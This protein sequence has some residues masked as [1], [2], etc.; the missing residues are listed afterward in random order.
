[1][2]K[3]GVVTSA[4]GFTI[5]I[6]GLGAKGS[7]NNMAA[8]SRDTT[9]FNINYTMLFVYDS[10]RVSGGGWICYRG[11]DANTNTIGYQLRT[12]SSTRPVT[13]QTGR[14]RILFTSADGGKWVP[15][16]SSSSTSAT[17]SKTVITTPINPWGEIAYYSSTTVLSAG[18]DVGTSA[19]WSQYILTLGYS[20]NRTN[21]ALVMT[22]PA[23]IYVKCTPQANGSAIIDADNPYVEAL[24]STNDGKI[25][26]YLGRSYSATNIELVNWHPVF[27]HDGTGIRFW[28]GKTIPEAPV[29]ADWNATSGLSQILNKPA[30]PSKTSDLTND[31]GFLSQAVTSLEGETGDLYLA[32]STLGNASVVSNVAVV[33][34]V[35]LGDF[36]FPYAESKTVVIGGTR[37]SITPVT[38]KT[39]VTSASGA[40]ASYQSGILTITNGSFSTGD[41]VTNGT[42]ISVY[43]TL[44]TDS[45]I[46]W[47]EGSYPS[48][49]YSTTLVPT[50]S[51]SAEQVVIGITSSRT[52]PV[53]NRGLVGYATVE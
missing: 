27:Y 40:T 38:K 42:A 7:Y 44:S 28:T 20:F 51:I 9:L 11:Y 26:I 22:Y 25:Y 53:V 21:V 46:E 2:L 16:N 52:A 43:T 12:N 33:T 50:L 41:S 3:N 48:I 45:S 6:N 29:N 30:I 5:N 34:G 19:L 17:A 32:H 10:T 36:S 13:D 18:T 39:V 49:S 24:P 47:Y 4:E 31:S 14:Y 1:M 23:S 37:T 35:E 15:A 8:S